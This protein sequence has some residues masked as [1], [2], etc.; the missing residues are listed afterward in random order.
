V[1]HHVE[2]PGL[3]HGREIKP[4]A[5]ARTRR[6]ESAV[7][8][9]SADSHALGQLSVGV[10]DIGHRR[11]HHDTDPALMGVRHHL[12]EHGAGRRAA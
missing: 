6:I 11:G 5:T 4:Y 8:V 1:K 12:G 9:G 2:D 10:R 3:V 7:G